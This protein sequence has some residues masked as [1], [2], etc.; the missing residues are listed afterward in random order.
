[1]ADLRAWSLAHA[2][3]LIATYASRLAPSDLHYARLVQ[4]FRSRWLLLWDA[5][6]LAALQAGVLPPEPRQPTRL[7]PPDYW[8]YRGLGAGLAPQIEEDEAP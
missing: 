8:R 5:P 2:D 1:M 7:A 4:P 3:G 6:V